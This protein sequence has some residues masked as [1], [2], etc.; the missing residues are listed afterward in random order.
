MHFAII[1][2]YFMDKI[3]T[4]MKNNKI[5]LVIMASGLGK[6][7]GS[8][9][10]IENLN[11]KPLVQWIIDTTEDLFDRR[12]VVTRSKEVKSLC[13]SLNVECIFHELPNR[14]DTIR[15]G[16]SSLMD[17]VDYC[18][19]TPSDQPLIKRES[20]S[21]MITEAKA[22]DGMIFRTCFGDKVGS[23]VGFHKCFFEELLNLPEGKGG[24]VVVKNNPLVT[25]KIAV[26]D[27]YELWDID[28]VSDLEAIRNVLE[29]KQS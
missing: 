21:K 29:M 15:L 26:E 27:E 2:L 17:E 11:N 22:A 13:D 1:P 9:K 7:F 19:F 23:P 25:Q 8:N 12:V 16:L 14:N 20:I 10:L 24:N 6:R 4:R 18:F 3:G 5:G 28:T